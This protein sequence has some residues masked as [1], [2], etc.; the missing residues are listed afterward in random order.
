VLAVILNKPHEQYILVQ[1]R[2][3]AF[4]S[5]D[6]VVKIVE[7]CSR[8]P[9]ARAGLRLHTERVFE[10]SHFWDLVAEHENKITSLE[11]EF[12]TPNMANISG[13][14]SSTLKD[15][16]KDTNSSQSNLQLRADPASS[17]RID[18]EDETIQGLVD[19]TSEGGGDISIKIKGFRKRIQTSR[20]IREIQMDDLELSGSPDEV[21]SILREHLK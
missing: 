18:P 1:E 17:L 13:T 15:L 8:T 11:F 19:Y 20:S 5:T 16:A 6:T 10:K 12:V 4:A 14:L 9:L 7:N 21:A 2:S 3:S